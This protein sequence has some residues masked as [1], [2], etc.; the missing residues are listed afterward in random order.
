MPDN[1]IILPTWAHS[2][3]AHILCPGLIEIIKFG[4]CPDDFDPERPAIED[5]G[6]AETTIITFSELLPPV[7]IHSSYMYRRG[8]ELGGFTSSFYTK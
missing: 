7:V 2:T 4:G 1:S 5:T 8:S 6:I 3:T